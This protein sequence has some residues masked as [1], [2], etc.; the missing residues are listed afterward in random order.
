MSADPFQRCDL[1]SCVA[2]HL[3]EPLGTARSRSRP[4]RLSW[5]G[6]YVRACPLLERA[7]LPTRDFLDGREHLRFVELAVGEE[8]EEGVDVLGGHPFAHLRSRVCIRLRLKAQDA[9]QHVRQNANLV[10]G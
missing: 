4:I 5:K 9:S 8:L 10:G 7:R 3:T 1:R 2:Q 6:I